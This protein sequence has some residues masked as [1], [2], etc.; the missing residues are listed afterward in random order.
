MSIQRSVVADFDHIAISPKHVTTRRPSLVGTVRTPM[1]ALTVAIGV[2][3][4]ALADIAGRANEVSAEPVFWLGLVCLVA[5]SALWLIGARASRSERIIMVTQLGM[6]LYLVKIMAYPFAL[7]LVDE[8]PHLRNAENIL[9]TGHLFGTVPILTVAGWFPGMEIVAAMVSSLTGLSLTVAGMIVV[10]AARLLVILALYLFFEQ[11]THSARLAGIA[12]L[13]YMANPELLFFDSQFAYESLGVALAAFA[14]F[15]IAKHIRIQNTNHHPAS[16]SIRTNAYLLAACCTLG[17]LAVTHHLTSYMLVLFLIL[18]ACVSWSVPH[19]ARASIA[20][21]WPTVIAT[22]ALAVNVAWMM[23]IEGQVILYLASLPAS[24]VQQFLT[25]L[26]GGTGRPLFQDGNGTPVPRWE[27]VVSLSAVAL[28]MVG[29]LIGCLA[30]W[31]RYRSNGLIVALAL[32][33]LL[34]PVTLGIRLLPAGG[35]AGNRITALTYFPLSLILA[36]AIAYVEHTYARS[37]TETRAHRIRPFNGAVWRLGLLV[38]GVVIILGGIITGAPQTWKRLPGPYL[39]GADQRS[40]TPDGMDAALWMAQYLGAGNVVAT[41][42][43]NR[44]LVLGY[45]WQQPVDPY[46]AGV[47]P[48]FGSPTYGAIQQQIIRTDQIDYLLVDRRLST[49]LP[50]AGTYFGDWQESSETVPGLSRA[51]PIPLASLMKFNDVA[52]INRIFDSGNI[53]IYGTGA[54]ANGQ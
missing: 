45:G 7:V 23:V 8:A 32:A 5:P 12:A 50:R 18:W 22:F 1:A 9:A 34:Y 15:A 19:I 39:V 42:T 43:G 52:H 40:A 54:I 33:S 17:A 25:M 30:V 37:R 10:G 38:A 6:A 36:I 35:V 2:A 16:W 51:A 3:V 13:L 53:V 49:A 4:L 28:I 41:D 14:L 29:L 31:R 21:M 24:M 20:H 26:A 44:A 48:L 47:L 27:L 11:V 46:K